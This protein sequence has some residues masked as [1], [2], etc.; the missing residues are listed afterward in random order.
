MK[1]EAKQRIF[2][3]NI[4]NIQSTLK[5]ANRFKFFTKSKKILEL[6]AIFDLCKLRNS[7]KALEIIKYA[8]RYMFI[9]N[10]NQILVKTL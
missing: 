4:S 10:C 1:H 3:N 7:S 5:Y 2:E 8:S 6:A 9:K